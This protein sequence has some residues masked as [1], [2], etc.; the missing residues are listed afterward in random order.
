M[1]HKQGNGFDLVFKFANSV[2]KFFLER[3]LVKSFKMLRENVIAGTEQ[4]K[5]NWKEDMDPSMKKVKRK[6]GEKRYAVTV[7]CD[8]FFSIF[9]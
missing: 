3:K 8:S 7:L 2:S 9:D 6:N 4:T 1:L 5:I